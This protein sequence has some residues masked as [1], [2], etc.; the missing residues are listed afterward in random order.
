MG[1]W[2][3]R[4]KLMIRLALSGISSKGGEKRA[5][6]IRKSGMFHH[7]GF[8]NYWYPTRIPA[9]MAMVS[10]GNNV[11]VS[12]DVDFVT[13]DLLHRL[14]NGS[15][16]FDT[17]DEKARYFFNSITV[18]NNVMIGAHSTIMY[19]VTIESDTIVAAGSVVT[20]DVKSGTIVG[21]NP[22][23]VIGHVDELFSR[24][25]EKQKMM[26]KNNND[27]EAINN[28]FWKK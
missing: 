15:E 24:R 11:T 28:Y 5:E 3:K 9:D 16:R 7:F 19:G 8:N 18:G 17:E 12:A 21:G 27:I 26:P 4:K 10:I 2:T 22:A 20:R 14:F 1:N 13:H 6:I 23:K 25:K